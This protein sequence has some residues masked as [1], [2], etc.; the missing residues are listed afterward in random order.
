MKELQE[1]FNRI[2]EVKKEQRDIKAT[3]KDALAMS[4]SYKKVSD[5]L[6]E[7]RDKKKEIELTIRQ[8]FAS[9][10]NKLDDLKDNIKNEIELLSDITLSKLMKG[11]TVAIT[12]EYS[13]TYE[14]VFTVKFRK[15]NG[16]RESE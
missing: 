4:E 2:Q 15:S 13:N 1:V 6:K 14:P 8:E 3:Y 9:E 5:E 7:L 11:E 16:G 12:D 10:L